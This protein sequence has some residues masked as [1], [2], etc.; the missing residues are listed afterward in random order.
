MAESEW[1]EQVEEQRTTAKGGIPMWVWGCGGGCL[2]LMVLGVVAVGMFAKVF[3][4]EIEK[5]QDP[6]VQQ[7]V[8]AQYMD[9]DEWPE[10]YELMGVPMVSRMSEMDM[11]MIF[12]ESGGSM[13]MAMLMAFPETEKEGVDEI[14][15]PEFNSGGMF[16][17]GGWENVSEGDLHIDGRDARYRRFEADSVNFSEEETSG[18]SMMIDL[19]GN[20]PEVVLVQ[21][22]RIAGDEGELTDEEVLTFIGE[23]FEVWGSR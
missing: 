15:D 10:E 3:V 5:A 20:G 22:T 18:P 9:F 7:A 2:L 6:E 16:G 11:V 12:G 13:Y 14:F 4:E 19:T 8:V 1:G 21:V 17:M 23:P